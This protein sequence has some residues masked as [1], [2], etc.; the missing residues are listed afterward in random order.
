MRFLPFLLVFCL[1][2]PDA[3][4]AQGA[5]AGAVTPAS[6]NGKGDDNWRNTDG[7]AFPPLAKTVADMQNLAYA[8]QLRDYCADRK[9][10]DAF[11]R[12]RLARFSAITGR[13]ESCQSLLDY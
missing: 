5:P 10:P 7:Y 12:E 2:C 6:G 4:H 3:A 8:M 9:V 11:V 13:E 1:A